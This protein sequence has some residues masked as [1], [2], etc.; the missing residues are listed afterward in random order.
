M[1]RGCIT[2]SISFLVGILFAEIVSPHFTFTAIL[3]AALFPL[4]IILR[5]NTLKFIL[6]SHL[7]LFF[8]GI[9]G[10]SISKEKK[11]YP[12][13]VMSSWKCLSRPLEVVVSDMTCFYVKGKYYELT[14]YFDAF[15]KEILSYALATRRGDSKQYYDGLNGVLKLIKNEECTEPVILHTDQGS[16]YSSLSYNELISNYN[17]KRSM[18][19]VGTPTDNPVNESL[20]GWIKEELI[21]DF[22][23]KESNDVEKTIKDYVHYYNNVRP[24][25]SLKY[26]TP[27]QFKT[28]LRLNE[29]F[30]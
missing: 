10:Y 19:R 3:V 13:L 30:L 1:G 4:C 7:A 29:S 24:A 18:S 27:I 23:L 26:K 15:T 2:Y 5:K 6:F 12:N 28:E 25:Y 16:V 14:F 11:N 21:L 8:A 20:N 17:I 9:G 22:K